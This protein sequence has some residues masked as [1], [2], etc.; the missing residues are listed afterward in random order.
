MTSEIVDGYCLET[1]GRVLD[2]YPHILTTSKLTSLTFATGALSPIAKISTKDAPFDQNADRPGRVFVHI[3][4]ASILLTADDYA[5]P[6]VISGFLYISDVAGGNKFYICSIY[7]SLSGP[8]AINID[9]SM[10]LITPLISDK[11]DK[12]A[13]LGFENVASAMGTA[14]AITMRVA[15]NIGFYVERKYQHNAIRIGG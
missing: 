5:T 12:I 9:T 3:Y 2:A 14:T 10:T 4:G 15:N 8:A 13:V 6:P 11:N 1:A 7:Q